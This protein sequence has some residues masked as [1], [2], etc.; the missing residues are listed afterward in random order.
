[1]TKLGYP[2]ILSLIRISNMKKNSLYYQLQDL[3]PILYD[4]DK[5]F[6]IVLSNALKDYMALLCQ[7][8]HNEVED[9]D[10]IIEATE[11]NCKSICR[12]VESIYEGKH[13]D[14]FVEMNKRLDVTKLCFRAIP[15]GTFFYRMRINDLKE[16]FGRRD[17]FHIPLNKR[18]LV[19]T[20][21]YSM[22]GYPCLYLGTSIAACWEE[23]DRPN[24]DSCM[25]CC[26][27]TTKELKV[28]C[29]EFPTKE[30]W[31]NEIE[32]YILMMP[33]IIAC[34]IQV[35]SV[36]SAYK[37]EYIIS[38][39]I[40][41]WLINHESLEDQYEEVLGISYTSVHINDEFGFPR[42]VYDNIA[43]PVKDIKSDDYCSVLKDC[44][45]LTKPTSEEIE[46]IK[47]GYC[48]HF[49]SGNP[50]VEEQKYEDSIFGFLE[51]SLKGFD[52]GK[53]Q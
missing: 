38:Q 17:M 49:S 39:L 52:F 35:D 10:H 12:V 1:M 23:M 22:P 13:Y 15:E 51:E 33:Y 29:L 18:G 40:T 5:D 6:R 11:S 44:F 20:Q 21:R 3:L 36:N 37:P 28:L 47:L 14:A 34:M 30:R 48:G 46:R 26:F 31:C 25:F 16:K 45:V 2:I 27:K 43:L 50:N 24:L 9:L 19:R 8:D 53:L 42:R 32:N 41:E 7:L 4:E